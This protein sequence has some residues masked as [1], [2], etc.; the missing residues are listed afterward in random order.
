MR[1][2]LRKIAPDEVSVSLSSGATVRVEGSFGA[3]KGLED[4]LFSCVGVAVMGLFQESSS[5]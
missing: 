2:I 4:D 1:I 5:H 3:V